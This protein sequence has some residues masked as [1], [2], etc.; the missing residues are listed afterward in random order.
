MAPYPSPRDV[1]KLNNTR[2]SILSFSE[3]DMIRA[4]A[5]SMNT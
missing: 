2:S 1:V 5:V 4:I 3:N